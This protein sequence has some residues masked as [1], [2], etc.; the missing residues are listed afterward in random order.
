MCYQ[1]QKHALILE[2]V[3][4]KS[5]NRLQSEFLSYESVMFKHTNYMQCKVYHSALSPFTY[6]I[7]IL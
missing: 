5:S 7:V 3:Y 4:R 6:D 1:Q 2:N